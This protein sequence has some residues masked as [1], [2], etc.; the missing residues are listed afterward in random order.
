MAIDTEDW[1]EDEAEALKLLEGANGQPV[2]LPDAT[3]TALRK[4][5]VAVI[6]RDTD[7]HPR[8]GVS[9]YRL[10]GIDNDPTRNE[11]F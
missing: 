6:A 4:R 8:P 10:A 1:P 7:I 2:M 3:G 5:G 9:A 11:G